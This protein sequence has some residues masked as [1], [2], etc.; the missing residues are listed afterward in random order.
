MV[1][2]VVGVLRFRRNGT[3]TRQTSCWSKILT[4]VAEID[5]MYFPVASLRERIGTRG[6]VALE[7][8]I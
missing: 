1:L 8:D 5:V 6:G 2:P 4:S 7:F 3:K